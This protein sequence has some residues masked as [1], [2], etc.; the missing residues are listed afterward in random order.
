M[1]GFTWV[2]IVLAGVVGLSALMS[3]LRGFV[4]EALALASWVAA[5][6]I[7][8]S[9]TPDAAELIAARVS[10][11]SVRLGIAFVAL[12]VA[13]LLVAGL[14]VYLVGLL[15]DRTGLSGT[16]RLL[17]MLFGIARGFILAAV[18]V[19]LAGLTP[20]PRDRWWAESV[21]LP[22]FQRAAEQLR[23]LLPE[24]V[25]RHVDFSPAPP[26]PAGAPVPA[27]PGVLNQGGSG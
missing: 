4:R 12:F 9:F 19:M 10:V 17:G 7:A 26:V 20:M 3:L 25:R 22:H 6:W 11:P 1:G 15:V 23:A 27:A 2:D 13:T 24:E 14:L 8:F 21:L 5:V 18:L 16:D